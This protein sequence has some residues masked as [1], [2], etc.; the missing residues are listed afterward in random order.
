MICSQ[1]SEELRNTRSDFPSHREDADLNPYTYSTG[2]VQLPANVPAIEQRAFGQNVQVPAVPFPS[3]T[4]YEPGFQNVDERRGGIECIAV[5]QANGYFLYQTSGTVE[6]GPS[7]LNCM[8]KNLQLRN[9]DSRARCEASADL[10]SL[11]VRPGFA[12]QNSLPAGSFPIPA[13]PGTLLPTGATAI[14]SNPCLPGVQVV[15]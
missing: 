3:S 15:S 10:P 6:S 4:I 12:M 8:M 11:S 5:P 7:H 2:M 14:S 13:G 1:Q 9:D